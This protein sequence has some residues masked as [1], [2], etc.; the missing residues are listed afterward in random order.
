MTATDPRG[1]PSRSEPAARSRRRRI[2]SVHVGP[3]SQDCSH[4]RSRGEHECGASGRGPGR[5]VRA[6]GSRAEPDVAPERN[7]TRRTSRECGR[8]RRSRG[9]VAPNSSERGARELSPSDGEH[10]GRA[11]LEGARA[12]DVAGPS[13]GGAP[14]PRARAERPEEHRVGLLV[15]RVQLVAHSAIRATPTEATNGQQSRRLVRACDEASSRASTERSW[16][17]SSARARQNS[18]TQ[19]GVR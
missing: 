3:S 12:S 8:P 18:A 15:T 13:L 14:R 16:R 9:H 2:S 17:R 4:A 7:G 19:R 5:T 11:P 10:H 1:A 6:L